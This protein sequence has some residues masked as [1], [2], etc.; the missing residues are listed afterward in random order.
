M[1]EVRRL[2]ARD[3]GAMNRELPIWSVF[4]YLSRLRAQERGHLAQVV[5]WDEDH[6]VGRGMVLFPEHD[7]L[8]DSAIREGCA[9][10]RDVF[11]GPA[12]RRRG[13]ARTIMGSLEGAARELE[14]V[15]V[16]LGV[17]LDE[18]AAPARALYEELGYRRAHGPFVTS[19]NLA[20]DDGPIPVGAVLVYLV[21]D[22]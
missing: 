3:L 16:G 12:Y 4:E 8:S 15:R 10:V 19:T 17:G 22:L 14:M 5:A 2:E 21:K 13:I 20:G 18:G 6:P 9:E 7:Q 1:V 11:V